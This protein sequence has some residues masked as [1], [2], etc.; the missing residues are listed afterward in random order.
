M[1]HPARGRL[2][3]ICA[4]LPE[5]ECKEW[6]QHVQ[7]R[8][9]GK[10]FAYLLDDHHGDGILGVVAKAASGE[11]RGLIEGDAKRYYAPP[12]L[13]H[14]GWV[15]LRLDRGFVDWEEVAGLVTDSYALVAPKK[16]VRQA[17]E[18]SASSPGDESR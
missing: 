18:K 2:G 14:H 8:V 5:A 9:R 7:Y 13:H 11:A 1:T 12:Y 3:A 4:E 10:T 16:L 17:G 6:G 15:G